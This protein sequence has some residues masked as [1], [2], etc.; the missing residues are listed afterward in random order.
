MSEIENSKQGQDGTFFVRPIDFLNLSQRS[1]N[2]LK[3]NNCFYI[4]DLVQ[5]TR[6]DLMRI[7]NLGRKSLCEIEQRL[8][9]IG[10]SLGM[11]VTSIQP[12]HDTEENAL[13]TMPAA[14]VLS[15][16]VTLSPTQLDAPLAQ[17]AFPPK[18][19]KLIKRISAVAGSVTTIQD[20]INLD[21]FSFGKLTTVGK[22][23]VRSLIELQ[24]QLPVLLGEK[25]KKLA[26]FNSIE[27]SEIDNILIEDIE[28]YLWALDEM[29]M[30]IALSRWGFNQQHETLEEVASQY[31]NPNGRPLTRERIRQIEKAINENL[32]LRL[33]IP[34][35]ILWANIRSKMTEDLTALLPNL[36]KCFA[37]DK[38]FY[39]FIELCCQVEEGSIS[40]IIFTKIPIKIIDT[41]FCT[42]PSPVTQE[43]IINELMSNYGYDRASAIHGIIQ[44]EKSQNIKVIEQ[45]IYPMKLARAEAIAHVLA[46]HPEGLPWKDI[47]KIVNVKGWASTQIDETRATHG[48]NDSECIYLC[49]K[50]AYRN[51]MFLDI[52]QFDI[53]AIVQ[54]LIDYLKLKQIAASHL[55][56]YYYQTKGQR[57]EIE[58]YTLRHLVREYGKD[59][60]L[61][62]DGKSGTDSISLDP[63][64]KRITQVDVII[65]VLNES[66]VAMTMQEIAERLK[67]KSAGHAALYISNLMEEGKV[68]RVDKMAYTTPE[69]AFSNIDTLAVMQVIQEI[70]NVK[71]VIVEAD[72]FREYVNLELNLSYSKYIYAALVNTQLK[73]L[74]WHRHNML[75]SKNPIPYRN[76]VD[77][78]GQLCNPKSTNTENAK[79]LQHAVWLTDAVVAS[80][81]QQWRVKNSQNIPEVGLHV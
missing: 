41:L 57:C 21:P 32:P 23:Y 27:L 19:H 68:V 5:C 81:I 6:D 42:T 47:A 60:G 7:S 50:G 56:D 14:S 39:G 80:A 67:S 1:R 31:N 3:G 54:H 36:A 22:L 9:E 10:L 74:G 11:V 48:F 66:K 20:L 78:C 75:F 4:H 33:T 43:F 29:K 15:H 8:E 49:G 71:D 38:L 53:P 44:L 77:M 58:Y 59:C 70:L 52:E 30:N 73:E 79:I 26:S 28:N 18:Y 35:K 76:L 46:S 65:K 69:K 62:F 24:K 51:L 34:P 2:C 61:Y 72:V 55:H 63:D 45:G 12:V 40:K 16:Q 17:V 25:E 64:S 37:T 13:S